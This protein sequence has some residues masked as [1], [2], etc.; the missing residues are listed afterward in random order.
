[1]HTV[2][3]KYKL[4]KPVPR[5]VMLENFKGVEAH[6]RSIPTLIRKYFAYDEANHTGHSVYL[7]ESEE[8]ATKFFSD[9]F[10]ANFQEKFGTKPELFGVDT[11]MVVDNEF[12][13]TTV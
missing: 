3:V 9:E 11:L 5:A 13:K 7:W 12:E 2:L 8:A 10:V 1:M 4:P 6:F